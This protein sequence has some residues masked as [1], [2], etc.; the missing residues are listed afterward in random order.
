ML[1]IIILT[2][3]VSTIFTNSFGQAG[4]LGSLNSIE[5]NI[6]MVPS[7]KRTNTMELDG[8]NVILNKRLRIAYPSYSINYSRITSRLIEV[9]IGLGFSRQ[10]C[11]Q[12]LSNPVEFTTGSSSNHLL[13]EDIIVNQTGLNLELRKYIDGNI[14]PIGKYIGFKISGS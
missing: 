14:A 1:K 7:I 11:Y 9:S 12:I 4:F 13:M 3:V 5:G 8:E 10:R 6:Y 2:I